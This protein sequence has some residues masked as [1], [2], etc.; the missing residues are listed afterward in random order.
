MINIKLSIIF[1]IFI[2]SC[3]NLSL[4]I[5]SLKGSI[6][7]NYKKNNNLKLDNI[8]NMLNTFEN[9]HDLRNYI[10]PLIKHEDLN[11]DE[12]EKLEKI[13]K[14]YKE[15]NILM[16]VIDDPRYETIKN[17]EDF[18]FTNCIAYEMV[19]RTE[20]FKKTE[21]L[22][23]T[24]KDLKKL[25]YLERCYYMSEKGKYIFLK[26]IRFMHKDIEEL[27]K[28]HVDN[29]SSP[30][31]IDEILADLYIEL[32][33]SKEILKA[34]GILNL[35]S[36]LTQDMID[37]TNGDFNLLDQIGY[38]TIKDFKNGIDLLINF[39]LQ[40]ERIYKKDISEVKFKKVTKT[41]SEEIKSKLKSY[42]IET[43]SNI[44][45]IS[46]DII[47][48]DL[49]NEFQSFIK[50]HH[51]KYKYIDTQPNYTRP[52]LH[53]LNAKIINLPINLNFP[54]EELKSLI[55][56]IKKDYDNKNFL[57]KTPVEQLG[58]KLEKFKR[59]N[60]E[61]KLPSR[62]IERRKDAFAKAFCVYDLDKVLSPIFAKKNEE[63]RKN[64]NDYKD[65]NPYTKIKLKEEISSIVGVCDDT[66]KVY[67]TLMKEYIDGKKFIELITGVK[68]KE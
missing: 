57:I 68:S 47:I 12:I 60:S 7:H 55:L 54:E 30:N 64:I 58:E 20:E 16:P 52:S 35:N 19:I 36:F 6:I 61:K 8:N 62:D 39:Y 9:D 4:T 59:P 38:L 50:K 33:K 25:N 67:R 37:L 43:D 48:S 53:F 32:E 18:E 17:Y 31:T 29:K 3:Y 42:Y 22:I 15:D 40:K 23:S 13:L 66:V 10:R 46:K 44:I 56:K 27:L 5:K 63:F 49:D 51:N 21:Y 2:N 28:K 34:Y 11:N 41:N 45:Q 65:D 14:Y 26:E 24:I 1:Y